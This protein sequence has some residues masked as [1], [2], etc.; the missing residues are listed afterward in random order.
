MGTVADSFY[1]NPHSRK[2]S[3]F[4]KILWRAWHD[5]SIHTPA[6]GVTLPTIQIYFHCSI[7]I[8]TPARG[9][10][11]TGFITG[12]TRQNFNPH[13][14]KG[15]DL[16]ALRIFPCKKISIH[17]PARGVTSSFIF[18]CFSCGISIHTPAR[19]VTFSPFHFISFP[20]AFQSTLPQGE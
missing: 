20:L 18:S 6:R 17:T 7:S 8:H 3:D 13:S 1:F 10:T 15:S 14:R 19:G 5:I 12:L 16:Q 4:S 11:S 9:V 2:G